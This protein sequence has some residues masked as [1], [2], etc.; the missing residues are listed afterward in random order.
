MEKYLG[1]LSKSCCETNHLTDDRF[2]TTDERIDDE[3]EKLTEKL[4]AMR[5]IEVYEK[6]LASK[7]NIDMDIKVTKFMQAQV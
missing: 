1:A 2:K 7:A 4:D 3:V 6:E 5:E